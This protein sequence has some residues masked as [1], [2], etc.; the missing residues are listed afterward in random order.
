MIPSKQGNELPLWIIETRRHETNNF[1]P[2][3]LGDCRCATFYW[4]CTFD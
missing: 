1:P 4:H 3:H 2:A